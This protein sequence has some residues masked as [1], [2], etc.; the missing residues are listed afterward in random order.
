VNGQV[1]PFLERRRDAYSVKML[2]N[3]NITFSRSFLDYLSRVQSVSSDDVGKLDL[4]RQII[5]PL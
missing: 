2:L 5:V 1:A 3:D 4:P